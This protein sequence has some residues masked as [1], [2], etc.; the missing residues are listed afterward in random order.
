MH[1]RVAQDCVQQQA[2]AV[3]DR[4]LTGERRVAGHEADDLGDVHDPVERV[5]A[6]RSALG[7]DHRGDGR[8][9][10]QRARPG[11]AGGVVRG[12]QTVADADLAGGRQRAGDERQLTGRVDVGA[13]ADG[14]HVRREGQG[15]LGQLQPE[16]GEPRG[17][18]HQDSLGRLR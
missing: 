3:D 16:L 12:D 18:A 17:G 5:G 4:G 9:R 8:E 1:A 7:R 11:V 6:L 15:H 14:R 2:G 10:V 13:R